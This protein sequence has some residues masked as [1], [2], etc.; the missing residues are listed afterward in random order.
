[1]ADRMTPIALVEV[2]AAALQGVGDELVFVGGAITGLLITDPAA[3]P[4]SATKDV[5]VIVSVTT[6]AD[7]LGRFSE[8]IRALGFRPDASEDAPICRWCWGDGIRLDVM[9]TDPKILGFSNRWFPAAFSQALSCRLPS[10]ATIRVVTAPYFIATKLEAFRSRG[11]GD[12]Q[13]SKDIEDIAA[14]LHGRAEIVDEVGDGSAELRAYLGDEAS[15]LLRTP[16]FVQ[17]LEG[18]LP[19]ED[20]TVVIQRLEGLVAM[21]D[22]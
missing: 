10:G 15:A 4:P 14:V 9:P 20:T 11:S 7:F 1:M 12:Y 22:R 13:G 18:H 21:R 3:R 2:I 17:A 19:G 16:E 8:Q 6:Q 5:D